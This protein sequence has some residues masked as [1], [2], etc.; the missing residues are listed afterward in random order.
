MENLW[1]NGS[2]EVILHHVEVNQLAEI[3]KHTGW[4]LTYDII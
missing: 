4:D 1:R 2:T 3:G